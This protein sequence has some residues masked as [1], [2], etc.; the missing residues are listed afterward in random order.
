M[1][2][3]LG[4]NYGAHLVA[5]LA[6]GTFAA[7]TARSLRGLRNG[8]SPSDEGARAGVGMREGSVSR[9]DVEE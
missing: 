6:F 2:L 9:Q 3:R 4:L 1:I 8:R 5:G 7:L